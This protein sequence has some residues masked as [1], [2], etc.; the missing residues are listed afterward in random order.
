VLDVND[1][2]DALD[3]RISSVEP[4]TEDGGCA[5]Q[6]DEFIGCIVEAHWALGGTV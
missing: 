6:C 2:F 3:G 5:T 1:V 4:D